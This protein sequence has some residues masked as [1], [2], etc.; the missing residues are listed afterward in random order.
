MPVCTRSSAPTVGRCSRR[1]RRPRTLNGMRGRGHVQ[2]VLTH[3]MCQEVE[4]LV[5]AA[6][7]VKMHEKA[8]QGQL[9]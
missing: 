1:Q 4:L 5:L 2:R 6:T 3:C 8:R 9:P 7:C